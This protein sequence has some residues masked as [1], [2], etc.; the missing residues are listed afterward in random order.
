MFVLRALRNEN[1]LVC[2]ALISWKLIYAAMMQRDNIV[3]GGVKTLND[4]FSCDRPEQHLSQAVHFLI[5]FGC[6]SALWILTEI[7]YWENKIN[8][9][10]IN[11]TACH[12]FLL[13]CEL[14]IITH[15]KNKT[16]MLKSEKNAIILYVG[17]FAITTQ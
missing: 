10:Q 14:W 7:L 13:K 5:K 1:K 6:R 16:I 4:F 11:I 8:Q 3:I 17:R 2:A 15:N 9:I 12:F